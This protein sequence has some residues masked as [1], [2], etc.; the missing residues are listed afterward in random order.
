M[1]EGCCRGGGGLTWGTQRSKD[2]IKVCCNE[3]LLTKG[4][5]KPRLRRTWEPN[6]RVDST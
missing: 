1:G 5:L 2:I 3:I 4:M 6:C